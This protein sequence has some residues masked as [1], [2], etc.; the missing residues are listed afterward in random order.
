MAIEHIKCC[1][2]GFPCEECDIKGEEERCKN[3]YKYIMEVV[4]G[5]TRR[6]SYCARDSAER[7][8]S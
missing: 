8:K 6:E 4:E 1:P 2:D 7:G 3:V 5:Q